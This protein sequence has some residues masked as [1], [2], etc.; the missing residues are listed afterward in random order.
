MESKQ[1]DSLQIK[2]NSLYNKRYSQ[3]TIYHVINQLDPTDRRANNRFSLSNQ[4]Q[5]KNRPCKSLLLEYM[6]STWD[7][8]MQ[9]SVPGEVRR[10]SSSPWARLQNLGKNLLQSFN[11]AKYQLSLDKTPQVPTYNSHNN[12]ITI[13]QC[14][15]TEDLSY[16]IPLQITQTK[17]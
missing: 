1:A 8:P 13:L 12:N 3:G 7:T 15:N 4:E 5:K 14:Y 10:A 17:K 16:F 11:L 2:Y 9:S 6:L